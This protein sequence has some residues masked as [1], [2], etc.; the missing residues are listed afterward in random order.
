[1]FY[2]FIY[3]YY[4]GK[5]LLFESEVFVKYDGGICFVLGLCYEIDNFCF[6]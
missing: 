2:F 6:L 1:M 4:D 3:I 5:R